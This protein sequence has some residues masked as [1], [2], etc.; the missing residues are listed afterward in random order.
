MAGTTAAGLAKALDVVERHGEATGLLVGWVHRLDTAE[1]KQTIEQRGGVADREDE[2]VAIRPV[3]VLGIVA[4]K[5]L[6][7][8]VDRRGSIHRG[9][10]MTGLRLLHGVDGKRAHGIDAELVELGLVNHGFP[11]VVLARR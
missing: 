1:I 4:Q 2:A 9:A 8:A 6:P 3:G 10:G 11:P 5:A 7:Q